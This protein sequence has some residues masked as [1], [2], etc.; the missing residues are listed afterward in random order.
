M[1]S[2]KH[3]VNTLISHYTNMIKCEELR[4]ARAR[5]LMIQ[6]VYEQYGMD[7]LVCLILRSSVSYESIREIFP[8]MDTDGLKKLHAMVWE[9]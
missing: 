7:G 1:E 6:D 3:N 5:R 9:L 8:D 2:I 4:P